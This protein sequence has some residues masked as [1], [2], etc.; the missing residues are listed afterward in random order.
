MFFRVFVFALCFILSGCNSV[1]IPND[2]VYKEIKTNTF[3]L[4]SWQ[5]I[6]NSNDKFKIYIEGDGASFDAYGM[7]TDNPTPRNGFLRKI[8][9][10]DKNSN[11]IYLARPCQ[12][13]KD[14]MCSQRHW[15]DAR[16]A[17]EVIGATYEAIKEIADDNEV[18]LVGF[19]GGAQVA[20]LVSVARTGLNVKKLI[21]IGGNLDHVAWS[22]YHKIRLLNQSLNLADY[23]DEYMK[24]PQMHY[25]GE[26]DKIITP[27]LVYDFVKDN[28][29][30]Y[31]VEGASHNSGF[32]EIYPFVW[33]D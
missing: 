19:S 1:V 31:V 9:F 21:T 25:V 14:E 20:G 17:V 28:S 11:V 8:A 16:F 5:K 33:D 4:A 24:I 3:K 22:K 6:T 30:V 13:L 7:P 12:F 18:V 26:N 15:T 23:R 29:L 10:G 2:F 27:S 32:E